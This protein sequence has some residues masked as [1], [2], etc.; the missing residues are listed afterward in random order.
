[1]P[2][3]RFL[4]LVRGSRV[5]TSNTFFK[6]IATK[7]EVPFLI[8][9]FL[10]LFCFRGNPDFSPPAGNALVTTGLS[11]CSL[12]PSIIEEKEEVE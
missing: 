9:S 10:L 7:K 8:L 5:S 6:R 4:F 11:L 1:M 2:H 12:M 3:T